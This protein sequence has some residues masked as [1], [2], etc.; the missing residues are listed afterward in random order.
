M[1]MRLKNAIYFNN[2][3][4]IPVYAEATPTVQLNS[5][6][7][8]SELWME[9]VQIVYRL[10]NRHSCVSVS[11]YDTLLMSTMTLKKA[12]ARDVNDIIL[13]DKENGDL[14]DFECTLKDLLHISYEVNRYFFP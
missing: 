4:I 1:L 5:T 13:H 12:R 11:A 2:K 10:H 14:H 6:T 7:A 8:S 9:N 3:L